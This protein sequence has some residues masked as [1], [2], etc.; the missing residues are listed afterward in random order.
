M[1]VTKECIFGDCFASPAGTESVQPPCCVSPIS[2]PI[3]HPQKATGSSMLI[4]SASFS[5]QSDRLVPELDTIVP[6]ESTKAYDMVDI[7]HSVSATSVCL[8]CAGSA[9][10]M[11]LCFGSVRKCF[12]HR[13]Y[14][15]ATEAGHGVAQN[16]GT[17]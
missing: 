5:I 12:T 15:W 3:P 10:C 8:V 17:E 6:L 16:K 9:T 4:I 13:P 1:V 7:I 2:S 11:S 14:H